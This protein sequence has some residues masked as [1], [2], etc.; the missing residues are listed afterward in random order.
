MARFGDLSGIVWNSRTGHLVAGHQ[1]VAEL[2]RR[3]A[4]LEGGAVVAAGERFPVR[5]VDWPLADEQAANLAANNPAIAG[6]FTDDAG[7]VL[8]AVQAADEELYA[9]LRLGEMGGDLG[10]EPAPL[11]LREWDASELVMS[12]LFTF[13]API[14]YQAEI[15]AVLAR[16]FPGVSF[17]E[18]VIH[19]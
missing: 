6:E 17:I 13:T 10:G 2:R 12:A 3:G 5:V 4:V 1:R 15:R 18:T 19:G 7:E 8:A 9:A 16:E 11:E 14:E